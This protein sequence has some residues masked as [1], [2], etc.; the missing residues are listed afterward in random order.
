MQL[1]GHLRKWNK[2]IFGI[3][4][5]RIEN[6]VSKLNEVEASLNED[7]TAQ[8]EHIRRL[9]SKFWKQLRASESILCQ[10]SSS[11]WLREGDSNT[12]FFH[13]CIN[14]NRRR[15]HLLT[16]NVEETWID[17]VPQMKNLA[18]QPVRLRLVLNGVPFASLSCSDNELLIAPFSTEE[19]KEV[20]WSCDGNKSLGP[21]GFSFSFFKS[22]WEVVEGDVVRYLNE[23]HAN[24]VLPGAIT[25]SFILLLPK[26]ESPQSLSECHPISLVGSMYKIRSKVLAER[27]KKFLSNVIS[28][29]PNTFFPSQK[30]LDGVVVINELVD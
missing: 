27:L 16:L 25:S 18:T 5:L 13:I 8:V 30:I 24:V 29:V 9:S 21:D 1:K 23:F 17:E 2:E 7:S 6:I 22:C 15:N 11:K 4:D 20:V 28:K 14:T 12:R 19:I 3:V 26:K 10:K